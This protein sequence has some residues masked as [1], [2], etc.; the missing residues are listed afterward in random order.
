MS[1]KVDMTCDTCAFQWDEFFY[2][3]RQESPKAPGWRFLPDELV[4]TL[5]QAEFER[6]EM[7]RHPDPA[8]RRTWDELDAEKATRIHTAR[9][10][11]NRWWPVVGAW[12][13]DFY[14][15]DPESE[16]NMTARHAIEEIA[17]PTLA[18]YEEKFDM[19][20]KPREALQ[21][22]LDGR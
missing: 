5:A 20:G 14:G 15:V 17:I 16:R 2:P 1:G 4:E 9:G 11:L 7:E 21:A 22:I 10:V 13:E 6:G 12:F 18:R 3:G 19:P 8:D